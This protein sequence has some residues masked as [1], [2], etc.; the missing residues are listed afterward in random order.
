MFGLAIYSGAN[1]A[2]PPTGVTA[3][4]TAAGL[5]MRTYQ[6]VAQTG[7]GQS[8]AFTTSISSRM[9]L[10]CLEVAGV[11]TANPIDNHGSANFSG[12]TNI[13]TP[14]VTPA[15]SGDLPIAFFGN[16]QSSSYTGTPNWTQDID[17]TTHAEYAYTEHGPIAGT[18]AVQAT[19]TLGASG[20]GGAA[21]VLLKAASS[22][23][24]PSPTPSP[25]PTPDVL[26][27]AGTAG[28]DS[29]VKAQTHQCG[30]PVA[31]GTSFTFN[32]KY[33]ETDCDQTPPGRNQ[34]NPD[35]G[36]GW[37][38]LPL[39]KQYTWTFHYIDGTTSDAAPGMGSDSYAP[40][41][42]FQIHGNSSGG[43]GNPTVNLGFMNNS[44]GQQE[45]YFE[46]VQFDGHPLWTGTYT[47]QET[48]DWKIVVNL[49]E[50]GGGSTSLYRNGS[51]VY[52]GS[53]Q[54][55]ACS[56]VTFWNFG[57]YKWPWESRSTGMTEINATINDMTLTTP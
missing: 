38:L 27:Q 39:G 28:K 1:T 22:T 37:M 56:T 10:S 45:W 24:T 48:D 17:Y 32:L 18:G 5:Q 13:S 34:A 29:W 46:I 25:T 9:T 8:W 57:P 16:S 6:R 31:S 43:C 50:S 30:T 49:A 7:D 55:T 19:A 4:E 3:I 40:S 35:T 53:S 15:N 51:L 33:T 20:I 23:P 54:S 52:S 47:P 14:S 11:D 12:Q 2:T 21:I 44:S 26:W 41:L 42:I 36:G